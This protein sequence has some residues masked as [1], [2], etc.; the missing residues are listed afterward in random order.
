MISQPR[1]LMPE[2]ILH[3]IDQH[4]TEPLTPRDV[5][6]ALHYSLCHLTHVTQRELG[7][8]VSDLILRCRM[9]AAQ[10]LLARSAL[11]V[12]DVARAVGFHDSAYFTRRFTRVTG[13]SPSR[14]RKL[15]RARGREDAR[16]ETCGAELQPAV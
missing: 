9:R 12:S 6:S 11:P 16:C 13:A 15:H 2:R 3:Y 1:E 10:R 7:A 14:W 4:Y 8:S 5:A